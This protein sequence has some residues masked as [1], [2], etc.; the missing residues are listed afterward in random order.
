VRSLSARRLKR[1]AAAQSGVDVVLSLRASD[2]DASAA[3]GAGAA[4]GAGAALVAS[5]TIPASSLAGGDYVVVLAGGAGEPDGSE[6][7]RYFFRLVRD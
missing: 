2:G 5:V 7:H 6:I 4:D 3:T 1:A